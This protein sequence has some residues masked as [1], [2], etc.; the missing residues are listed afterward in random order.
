MKKGIALFLGSLLPMI[1]FASAKTVPY[2]SALYDDKEWIVVDNNNDGVTW[3]DLYNNKTYWA[4]ETVDA[5]DWLISPSIHLETGKK[6]ELTFRYY[7]G[8]SDSKERFKVLL[9]KGTTVSALSTGRQLCDTGSDGVQSS[10]GYTTITEYLTVDADGDY[11]VGICCYSEVGQY[12]LQLD[13]FKLAYFDED[14]IPAQTLPWSSDFSTKEKFDFLWLSDHGLGSDYDGTSWEWTQDDTNGNHPHFV[15][16]T[17]KDMQN[18]YLMSPELNFDKPGIYKLTVKS[19]QA[20]MAYYIGQGT[21]FKDFVNVIYHKRYADYTTGGEYTF[22]VRKAG[23]YRIAANNWTFGTP[24]GPFEHSIYSM[25]VEYVSELTAKTPPYSTELYADSNWAVV[26]GN[27][28]GVT[29]KPYFPPNDY[30]HIKSMTWNPRP[31][32][33]WAQSAD[34]WL[35]SPAIHLEAGKTYSMAFDIILMTWYKNAFKAMMAKSDDVTDLKDG[36]VLFDTGIITNIDDYSYGSWTTNKFIISP[37]EDG[38]YY[39]G[40]YAYSQNQDSGARARNFSIEEYVEVPNPPTELTGTVNF[41]RNVV[42]GWTLP[43]TN[44][45]GTKLYSKLTGIEVYRDDV[46]VATLDGTAEKWVDSPSTG[47]VADA[48]H[49]Y[50]LKAVMA[51]GTS[52]FSDEVMVEVSEALLALPYASDFSTKEKFDKQWVAKCYESTEECT[53]GW[54]YDSD[55]QCVKLDVRANAKAGEAL[56]LDEV[57]FPSEGK[58]RMKVVIKND[59]GNYGSMKFALYGVRDYRESAETQAYF[60]ESNITSEKTEYVYDFDVEPGNYYVYLIYDEDNTSSDKTDTFSLYS[61]TLSD[62][63]AAPATGL[64]A[65]VTGPQ[66]NLSWTNPSKD[67]LGN[68]LTDLSAVEV[69]RDGVLLTNITNPIPGDAVTWA[70]EMP[71]K[72]ENT[73][74]VVPYNLYGAANDDNPTKVIVKFDNVKTVPY[75]ADFTNWMNTA[76]GDIQWT[77]YSEGEN[78]GYGVTCTTATTAGADATVKSERILFEPKHVYDIAFDAEVT[79]AYFSY[80]LDI[81]AGPKAS[82]QESLQQVKVVSNDG[83]HHYQFTARAVEDKGDD[84][85]GYDTTIEYGL[86][87]ITLKASYQGKISISNFTIVEDETSSVDSLDKQVR[88]SI[89]DDKLTFSAVASHIAIVD[90]SGKTVASASNA[91]SIGLGALSSGVYIFN[92]TVD[93]QRIVGK[94]VK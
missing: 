33:A 31:D 21:S 34:D 11:N 58:Y 67:V 2:S 18:E 54:H 3:E 40:L 19:S 74:W 80:Y 87:V 16:S 50:K 49:V 84:A 4:S 27:Y 42:L 43:T 53:T 48:D 22:A 66:V 90:L 30:D 59:N 7:T 92:A 75:T 36:T 8:L 10:D 46:L 94:F 13:N 1:V 79:D 26:D 93:G 65:T 76:D 86:Q 39:F 82:S 35:I 69:Y 38:D 62:V 77:V 88:Y 72:G 12:V 6:Y 85:D 56:R 41:E 24:Y 14:N 63:P 55:E 68:D 81:T 64:A 9:G 70:D 5:D 29:W 25:S 37:T 89:K 20:Y 47:L 44:T 61:M 60:T 23:K 78:E 83:V 91:N 73:Y 51:S 52:D 57:R 28:D 17:E 45:F 71:N 32:Y 15:G